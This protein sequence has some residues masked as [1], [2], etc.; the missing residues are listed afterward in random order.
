MTTNRFVQLDALRFLFAVIV[1][2]G[3]AFG[4]K[5]TLVHGAFAV[6][7]FFILSGFVL[8]HVLIS[9]PASAAGFAWARLARLYPLHL[10]TL[11]WIILIVLKTV[12]QDL[13]PAAPELAVHLTMLQGLAI[14]SQHTWNQPSWSISVEF[15]VNI[16]ILYP[17]VRARSTAAAAIGALA[18]FGTIL[19]VWGPLFD[20]FGAERVGTPLVSGGLLRGIGGILLGYLVYEAYLSLQARINLERFRRTA[21]AA[22]VVGLFT[23]GLSMAV[24]NRWLHFLPVPVSAL[25]ILQMATL[26]GALSKFLSTRFFSALGDISYSIYLL[27]GP[28]LLTFST[29]GLVVFDTREG[30]PL[31]WAFY[32]VLLLPL[33]FASFRYVERPAQRWLMRL[34]SEWR[35]RTAIP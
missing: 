30:P 23:L 15:L 1:V 4:F 19:V 33:S 14:L 35:T 17:V 28:L 16:L 27:H 3:H 10:A 32:F 25:L 31:V 34:S 7:F 9:R 21:T 26:P 18:A 13:L 20:S 2:L 5:A 24:D 11:A 8:S 6:D 29:A 22:E 12:P